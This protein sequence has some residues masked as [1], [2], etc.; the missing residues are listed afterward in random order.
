MRH[1]VIALLPAVTAAPAVAS[2]GEGGSGLARLTHIPDPVWMLVNLAV[3]L[4]LLHR[5][6]GRPLG[7]FLDARREGIGVELEEAQRKL[8]EAEALREQVVQRLQQVEGEV[9]ELHARAERE[10]QAEAEE[11]ARQ[12][13]LEE[14]RFLKRVNEEIARRA[15]ETRNGL[16]QETARLTAQLARDLLERE[17]TDSDRKLLLETSLTAMRK[18]AQRS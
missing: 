2:T 18:Q 9:A 17:L 13:R 15:A 1:W 6:V 5:F 7:R 14:E 12:A 3:F 10:G 8:A 16:A 11:I 4:F